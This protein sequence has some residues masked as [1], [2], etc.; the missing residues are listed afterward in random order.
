M[1]Q[2]ECRVEEESSC[3]AYLCPWTSAVVPAD[4]Q[5]PPGSRNSGSPS[6]IN[7]SYLSPSESHQPF[8][9]PAFTAAQDVMLAVGSFVK[10]VCAVCLV[11]F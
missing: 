11:N 10:R 7:S 8:L 4:S 5:E 3:I 1:P 2:Q 9:S 6:Q